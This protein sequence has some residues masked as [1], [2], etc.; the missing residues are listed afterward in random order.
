M[1]G[2]LEDEQRFVGAERAELYAAANHR[3]RPSELD[4]L[5]ALRDETGRPA[6]L[7]REDLEAFAIGDRRD[8]PL[9]AKGDALVPA[10][11]EALDQRLRGPARERRPNEHPRLVAGDVAVPDHPLAIAAD[12]AGHQTDWLVRDLVALA[13][14]DVPA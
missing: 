1:I 9:A 13:R 3:V 4:R 7:G 12:L 5:A 11:R 10:D 14:P 2:V 6:T 8:R